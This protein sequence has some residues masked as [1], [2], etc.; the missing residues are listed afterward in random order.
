MAINRYFTQDPR[1]SGPLQ[2][3]AGFG[4]MR[5]QVKGVEA[6]QELEQNRLLS[7]GI[8]Q[9]GQGLAQGISQ[10]AL[11]KFQASQNINRLQMASQLAAQNQASLQEQRTRAALER[12]A[13]QNYFT[14]YGELAPVS[15]GSAPAQDGP[16]LQSFDV[17]GLGPTPSAPAAPSAGPPAPSGEGVP[18]PIIDPSTTAQYREAQRTIRMLGD[19]KTLIE[20]GDFTPEE[21]EQQLRALAPAMA[22]AQQLARRTQP[23]PSPVTWEDRIKLGANEPGGVTLEKDG[24]GYLFHDGKVIKRAQF[25]KATTENVLSATATKEEVEDYISSHVPNAQAIRDSGGFIKIQ[26]DGTVDY[27]WPPGGRGGGQDGDD[28]RKQ[29][30]KNLEKYREDLYQSKR[31]AE[32]SRDKRDRIRRESGPFSTGAIRHELDRLLNEKAEIDL[33]YERGTTRD[34]LKRETDDIIRSSDLLRRKANSGVDVSREVDALL[35]RMQAAYP[36]PTA[37]NV[38]PSIRNT[39]AQLAELKRLSSGAIR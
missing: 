33:Y 39:F 17:G 2:F 18:S 8:A 28:L 20:L 37:D 27:E 13:R 7:Q 10:A 4:Q 30:I 11:V 9:G 38:P 16:P 31:D 3:L 6:Q 19:Q 12:Q 24:G 26:P 29:A 36:D 15:G 25:S 32:P 5:Q 21:E 34:E 14:Q 23:P 22:K 1:I 35:G